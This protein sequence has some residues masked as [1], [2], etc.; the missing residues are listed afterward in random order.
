MTRQFTD[1]ELEELARPYEEHAIQALRRGDTDVV[2]YW[3]DS[4]EEGPAGLDGL[5]MHALARKGGKLRQDLGE[6]RARAALEQVGTAQMRTWIDQFR[7]GDDRGAITDLIAVYRHQYGAR[8][9]PL[10]ETADEVILDL[11]PCG[12]GGRVD[13]QGVADK[14]PAWYGDWSDGV[15]SLCQ[16]CKACQRGLNQELGEDVWTTEKGADG[17]CR[18][19]FR[20]RTAEGGALF[21]PEERRTLVQ[22][23]VQQARDRLDHGDEDIEALLRGQRKEWMPWHDFG[24]VWLEHF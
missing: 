2:R 3:L 4:M 1:S 10:E 23:R 14:H 11:A 24:I 20:K 18:M 9:Q 7:A 17:R 16:A 12:S 19:R 6:P 13:R 15:N 5:S 8:L 22:T 21:T